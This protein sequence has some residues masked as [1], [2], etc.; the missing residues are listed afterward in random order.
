MAPGAPD[1]APPA[2]ATSA[3]AAA[4]TAAPNAVQPIRLRDFQTP[5]G[6]A[7]GKVPDEEGWLTGGAG[8]ALECVKP[9]RGEMHLGL[10]ALICMPGGMTAMMAPMYGWIVAPYMQ[11]QA[12]VTH[13]WPQL[14]NVLEPGV[15]F[16][17]VEIVDA[18][19]MNWGTG[20]DVGL[21]QHRFRRG[22]DA[23]R[24]L[25]LAS[26]APLPGDDRWVL[27]YSELA[28][29]ETDDGSV[30]QGL[31]ECWKAYDRSKASGQQS[32]APVPAPAQQQTSQQVAA[33]VPAQQQT[34]Q[35]VDWRQSQK[36]IYE[37]HHAA[38]LQL[39]R[40]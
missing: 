35:P 13:V 28:V 16:G 26:T 37:K 29:P 11:A 15:G 27:Y 14:R 3:P 4:E 24:G 21:F 39:M 8:G 30:Y 36:E 33:P 18:Q 10:T 1:A 7:R 12:A 23:W 6:A 34:S 22:S 5:D 40:E 2:P 20:F 31:S 19:P 25:I 17:Y 38:Y 32:A 9:G